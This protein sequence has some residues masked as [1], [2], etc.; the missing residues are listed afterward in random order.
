[1]KESTPGRAR[2][3][4][5]EHAAHEVLPV[6]QQVEQRDRHQHRI[7]DQG[8]RHAAADLQRRPDRAEAVAPVGLQVFHQLLAQAGEVQGDA[9]AEL[10]QP[11]GQRRMQPVEQL[12][13]L[14]AHQRDFL[15]EHRTISS[16]THSTASMTA[17]HHDDGQQAR[18]AAVAQLVPPVHS[19]VSA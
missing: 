9:Q 17:V 2:R 12:R 16:T 18:H 13:D 3:D 8:Q 7:A 6:E 1:V 10:R 4:Q 19:G 14:L 5:L 15:G 11:G